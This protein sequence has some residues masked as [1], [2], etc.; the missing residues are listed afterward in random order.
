MHEWM[1]ERKD[2]WMNERMNQWMN[3]QTNK[4]HVYIEVYGCLK[5]VIMMV[6]VMM[7]RIMIHMEKTDENC[8]AME[9][10]K[11]KQWW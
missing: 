8:I 4:Q 11:G 6:V 3:K 5:I 2:E 1:K 10:S 9:F 7:I